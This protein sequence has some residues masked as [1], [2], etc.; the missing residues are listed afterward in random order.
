MTPY[1]RA[2]EIAEICAPLTQPA[3]QVRYLVS[4]G[5]LVKRKPNGAPLVARAEFER[6]MVGRQAE[7]AKTSEP[8]RTA[9]LQH[10]NGK[11]AKGQTPRPAA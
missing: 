2:D 3:A 7:S 10:I 11:K 5:L 8:N 4:L 1:L 9:L 6:A